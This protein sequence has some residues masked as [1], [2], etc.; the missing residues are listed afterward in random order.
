MGKM[1][2]RPQC[3]VAARDCMGKNLMIV[4][5]SKEEDQADIS[6]LYF[7]LFRDRNQGRVEAKKEFACPLLLDLFS[8]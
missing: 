4:T 6:L 1:F 7:L 5:I 8:F 3:V 2:A